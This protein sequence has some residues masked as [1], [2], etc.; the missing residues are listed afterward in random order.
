MNE[1]RMLLRGRLTEAERALKA[2]ETQADGQ[3]LILRMRTLPTLPLQMLKTEEI[4][5]AA[6]ALHRLALEGTKLQLRIAEIHEA[7][8][9]EG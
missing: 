6:T 5:S 2:V 4:V 1:E 8:G 9:I 3:V 7:L